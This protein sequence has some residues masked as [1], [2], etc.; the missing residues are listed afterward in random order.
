VNVIVDFTDPIEQ[1]PTLGDA[2]RVEARIVTWESPDVLKLPIGALFRSGDDWAVF[3]VTDG[4]AK[5]QRITI[6]QRNDL[7]AEIKQGLAPGDRVIVHP[8]D[9]VQEGKSVTPR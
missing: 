5:L 8:S 2:F 7:E 1:R 9:K 3:V 4:R 6:G